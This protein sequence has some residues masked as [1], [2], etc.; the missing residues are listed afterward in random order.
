MAFR[1]SN[2]IP[3]SGY[4]KAKALALNT[5]R[6]AQRFHDEFASGTD[7]YQL[8]ACWDSL[9][10]QIAKLEEVKAIDGIG[11]Y[12]KDQEDDPAYDVA[13][14]FNALIAA[15]QAVVDDINTRVP[16]DS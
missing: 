14:E 8:D 13:T 1:A 15:C 2:Q 12:A 9:V 10:N 11:Q 4:R 16:T 5:Q 6:S 7:A 3:E